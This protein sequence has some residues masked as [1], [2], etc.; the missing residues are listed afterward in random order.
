MRKLEHLPSRTPLLSNSIATPPKK[1]SDP[2]RKSMLTSH[3]DIK[4]DKG[5]VEY[6]K[7]YKV[8]VELLSVSHNPCAFKGERSYISG[9][10]C[11]KAE[12]TTM[13]NR[14]TRVAVDGEHTARNNKCKAATDGSPAH[15]LYRDCSVQAAGGVMTPN[16]ALLW[17]CSMVVHTRLNLS[18]YK[19]SSVLITG[20]CMML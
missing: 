10:A 2:I 15:T 20:I 14:C 13:N 11:V 19:K 17:Y 6:T 9:S 1:E 12:R 16:K 18:N 8:G 5:A 3:C 7:R 4:E